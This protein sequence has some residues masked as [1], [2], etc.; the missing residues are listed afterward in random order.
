[1]KVTRHSNES[2]GIG[3]Y[4]SL[5]VMLG[6]IRALNDARKPLALMRLLADY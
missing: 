4:R 5:L 2:A 1:M 3:D 6:V